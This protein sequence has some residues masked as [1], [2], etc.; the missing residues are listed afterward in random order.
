MRPDIAAS[1][2]TIQSQ[3]G[4]D[5]GGVLDEQ[6]TSEV[7]PHFRQAMALEHIGGLYAGG[8]FQLEVGSYRFGRSPGSI[9]FDGGKPQEP[10][11]GL[12]VDPEGLVTLYP[13][14]NGI[15]IDGAEVAGPV[16]INIGQVIGVGHDRF[17]LRPKER[18][19]VSRRGSSGSEDL[20]GMPAPSR[21]RDVDQA[22]ISWALDARDRAQRAHWVGVAGPVQVHYQISRGEFFAATPGGVDFGRVLLGTTDVVYQPPAELAGANRATQ[23]AVAKTVASMPGVPVTLDLSTQSLAIIGPRALTRAVATWMVLSLAVHTDPAYLSIIPNV[24]ADPVEWSWVTRLPH[25]QAGNNT[26]LTVTVIH[27]RRTVPVP[28]TGGIA[29]LEPAAEVPDG[30]H[31]VLRLAA[32]SATF[33]DRY[34]GT[35]EIE[36]APIGLAS[37]VAVERSLI[38]SQHLS[39]RGV[40]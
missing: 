25:A 15:R 17:R 31:A 18:L 14:P 4:N 40:A 32:D 7:T 9:M 36:I 16:P 1:L 20:P 10:Q 30:A 35:S 39:E 27:E 21:G 5:L 12:T 3:L 34:A 26:D 23:D 28:P 2:Q 6:A 24:T 22:I 11:F 29:L 19:S 13:A 37:A 33:T 38:M 8:A